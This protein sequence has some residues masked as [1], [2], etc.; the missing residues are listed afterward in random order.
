MSDFLWLT[1]FI[2]LTPKICDVDPALVY[3]RPNVYDAGP[4]VNQSWA[5]VARC[6]GRSSINDTISRIPSP[7][8][9]HSTNAVSMLGQRRRRWPNIETALGECPVSA[10][11]SFN[12]Q[13]TS[14]TTRN[15]EKS[16]DRHTQTNLQRTSRDF[17]PHFH[18]LCRD[19]VELQINSEFS[20][21]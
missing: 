12:Q 14:H 17:F 1:R 13:Y 11:H 16:Q 5:G 21:A 2:P 6:L 15:N 18:G 3:C 8:T 4:T 10:C 7:N 9:R 19:Y 20:I